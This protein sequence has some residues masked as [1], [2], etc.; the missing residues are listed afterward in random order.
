[1][2]RLRAEHAQSFAKTRTSGHLLGALAQEEGAPLETAPTAHISD[3]PAANKFQLEVNKDALQ[4]GKS[5]ELERWDRWKGELGV[6]AFNAKKDYTPDGEDLLQVSAVMGEFNS[7]FRDGVFT[8]AATKQFSEAAK[9]IKGGWL[10]PY[11]NVLFYDE[12]EQKK[13]V[14]AISDVHTFSVHCPFTYDVVDA[15]HHVLQA[16]IPKYRGVQL[17]PVELTFFLGVTAASCT[18]WHTDSAEHEDMVLEL[19]TLTL[20]TDGTT[21]MCI[22]GCK[23]TELKEPFDTVVFDPMLYHRSGTT[24]PHVVKLSIHWKLR[25]VPVAGPSGVKPEKKPP[26]EPA[27]QAAVDEELEVLGARE[28]PEAV[29]RRK[30]LLAVP[31]GPAFPASASEPEPVVKAVFKA[32]LGLVKVEQVPVVVKKEN[33]DEKVVVKNE[34]VDKKVIVKQETTSPRKNSKRPR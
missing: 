4:N 32:G 21:S 29:K 22:A 5:K 30:E 9:K 14:V 16:K 10:N 7:C 20:L 13:S 8:M 33:E 19:T 25:S 23:E 17:Q 11:K 12:L 34:K 2:R 31:T 6:A 18:L 26:V 1:M 3:Y 24:F 27:W 15:V 28:D